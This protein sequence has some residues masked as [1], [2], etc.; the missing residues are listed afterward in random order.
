MK[1]ASR[2][3]LYAPLGVVAVLA[4][5]VSGDWWLRASALSDR[6]ER[7]NGYDA[8]PGITIF[9]SAKRISGFPFNLD[10]S[11]S[12]FV[13]TIAAPNGPT[14]WHSEKFV[15]HALTYGRSET[16]F[17]AAGRQQLEWA[18][19]HRLDFAVGALRASAITAEDGLRRFDLDLVGFGSKA[20]TA[21]R[22]QLHA[23]TQPDGVQLFLSGD[24]L[25]QCSAPNFRYA[26]TLAPHSAFARLVAGTQSW[27]QA[28]AG[29]RA[30]GSHRTSDAK[31]GLAHL[32]GDQA[33]NLTVVADAICR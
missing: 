29:W 26:A 6:L 4:A 2:F 10:T 13:L 24:G 15:M 8:A 3:F 32:N 30:A 12:D 17:E 27:P 18:G 20:F 31:S 16:I 21:Q 22:L 11:L 7:L 19:G 25:S 28:V 23:R 14:R 1:Y 33:L 9:Y 5:W